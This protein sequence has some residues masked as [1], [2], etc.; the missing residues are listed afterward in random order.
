VNLTS[1][2]LSYRGFE[3]F[4]SSEI[5][6]ES[7]R[8]RGANVGGYRNAEF[9]Q[10]HRRL[11]TT[12]SSAERDPIAADLAKLLLDQMYYLPLT[13]SSDVS[14]SKKSIQGVT[15]VFALQRVTGWNIHQ[16][17]VNV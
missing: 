11:F 17:D 12:I 2:D 8:W 13:Y 16:W 7:T 3:G 15:G 10:L 1:L 14:A 9:D 6:S 4:L 5:S